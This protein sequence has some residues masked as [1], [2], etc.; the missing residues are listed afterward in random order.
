MKKIA[1][2]FC[3]C[4]IG[5]ALITPANAQPPTG[6]WDSRIPDFD[7]GTW[8]EKLWGGYEGAPGNEILSEGDCYLFDGALLETVE[9][10]SQE[11]GTTIHFKEYLTFY[12]NGK[13]ELSNINTCPWF[14]SEDSGATA[15]IAELTKTIVVTKK[16]FESDEYIN[17]TGEI[18]FILSSFG[19]FPDYE[20]YKVEVIAYYRGEPNFDKSG[21]PNFMTDDL[22]FAKI[23]ITGPDAPET[24]DVPV[25]IKP[26]SCP[27]PVNVKSKGVLPV[28]IL[29]TS[30]L[31][32]TTIVPDSIRLNGISPIRWALEDVATPYEPFVG[33]LNAYD[34][35]EEGADG[36]MDLTLKFDKQEIINTFVEVEDRDVLILQ[37][38]GELDDGT[39]I[40]GEDVIIVITPKITSSSQAQ[41]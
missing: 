6:T 27:N 12:G 40:N 3:I 22:E 31:D 14:N 16:Y 35:T 2:I 33:K 26:G 29:G 37:L 17:P 24:I 8:M 10:M 13:L 23:T 11:S 36:Y 28:A 34:C 5:I 9:L 1:F 20:G 30:D 19:E 32:V 39:L 38:T 41:W 25:D 21:Y 4:L 7:A 15:F 18:S